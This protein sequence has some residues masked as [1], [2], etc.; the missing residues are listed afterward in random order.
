MSEIHDEML[1]L[2]GRLEGIQTVER[3][4][5]A[6]ALNQLVAKVFLKVTE[7]LENTP[8]IIAEHTM[9]EKPLEGGRVEINGSEFTL[10]RLMTPTFTLDMAELRVDT[11]KELFASK[12]EAAV[13]EYMDEAC[14]D[15]ASFVTFPQI[16]M[17]RKA[18]ML[19]F[20]VWGCRAT[21]ID[22]SSS[23]VVEEETL[24]CPDVVKSDV[25]WCADQ[26]QPGHM[27]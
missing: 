11:T 1:M 5:L 20:F 17:W 14:R 18:F 19:E 22:G 16:F 4:V 7:P 23:T 3:D 15:I 2:L 6:R 13:K 27:E 26:V 25:P 8:V 21:P 12:L 10:E 24:K 9:L